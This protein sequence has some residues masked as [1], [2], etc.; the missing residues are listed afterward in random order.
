MGHPLAQTIFTSLYI[1]EMLAHQPLTLDNIRFDSSK[2]D[3]KERLELQVLRAYVIG[4][5]KTC[6]HVNNRI[7]SEHYYEVKP[8]SYNICFVF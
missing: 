4:L 7:Q 3:G 1:D 8:Q 5:I 6:D 2:A